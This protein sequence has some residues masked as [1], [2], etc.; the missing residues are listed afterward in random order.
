MNSKI[1]SYA[2]EILSLM[3]MR[4]PIVRKFLKDVYGLSPDE[5]D[6]VIA[7]LEGEGYFDAA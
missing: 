2:D 3:H 1:L 5:V 4:R 6:A 7:V